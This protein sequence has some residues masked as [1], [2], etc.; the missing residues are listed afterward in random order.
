MVGRLPAQRRALRIA[1][2]SSCAA[3][4]CPQNPQNVP[5]SDQGP[6]VNGRPSSSML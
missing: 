1:P 4:A 6:S 3:A 2:S 5:A